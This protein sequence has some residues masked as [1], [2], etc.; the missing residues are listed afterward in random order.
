MDRTRNAVNRIGLLIGGSVLLAVGSAV[1]TRDTLGKNRLPQWWAAFTGRARWIDPQSW[2]AAHS[3]QGWSAGV[4]TVLL[5]AVFSAAALIAFEL[6]RRTVRQLPLTSPGTALDAGALTSA[7]A[8]RLRTLPGVSSASATLHKT[9]GGTNLRTR[10]VLDDT[11]SPSQVLTAMTATVLPEA[12]GF[13]TS[14]PL[15]LEARF[16]VRVHRRTRPR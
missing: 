6:R 3:H 7:V 13:L 12:R 11:A 14:H 2:A 9:A 10:L 4:T 16:T 8:S 1:L 15:A 5:L